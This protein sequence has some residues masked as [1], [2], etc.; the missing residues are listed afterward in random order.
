MIMINIFLVSI[1][2]F[3]GIEIKIYRSYQYNQNKLNNIYSIVR[4]FNY[5]INSGFS[6][7]K[8]VYRY[9]LYR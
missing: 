6:V 5:C 8:E 9:K 7:E 3:C 1:F 2:G 4:D